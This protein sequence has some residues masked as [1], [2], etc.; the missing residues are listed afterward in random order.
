MADSRKTWVAG[1]DESGV[2]GRDRVIR[3]TLNRFRQGSVAAWVPSAQFKAL[4]TP[5]RPDVTAATPIVSLERTRSW[6]HATI[7]ATYKLDGGGTYTETLA[8]IN[9]ATDEQLE[10]AC[11]AIAAARPGA[12]FVMRSATLK[13][14]GLKLRNL[15]HEVWTLGVTEEAQ[16]L[17][18]ARGA[19][20]SSTL[21]HDGSP[22]VTL[23]S[24]WAKPRSGD[25]GE[26]FSETF[27]T[28]HIDAISAVVTGV[29]VASV[30]AETTTQLY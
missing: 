7:T 1:P 10:A 17:A 26:R 16:A 30:R 19:V 24:G 6:E 2:T 5:D 22:L 13:P 12:V 15:G 11:V 25:V 28:G 27:S 21:S 9:D 8:T 14:L 3:Y 23:Q 20:R 18:V 29:F 4:G